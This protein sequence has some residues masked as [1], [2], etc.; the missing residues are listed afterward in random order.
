MEG[1]LSASLAVVS[2]GTLPFLVGG[3]ALGVLLGA[4]PGVTGAMGI[5]LLLPLTFYMTVNNA[6]TLMVSMYVGAIAGGLV[7]AIL[8]RIPGEPSSIVTTFD[9]NPMARKGQPGKA[10]G[11]AVGAS[12][13]GGLVSWAALVALTYPLSEIAVRLRPF[14]LL[15]LVMMALVLIAALGQGSI[16]KGLISGLLGILV[17]MPG[18]DPSAGN[19]RLTFGIH[20]LDAGFSTLAVLIGAYAV[21]QVMS[22]LIEVERKVETVE[23]TMGSMWISMREWKAQW[24]NLIRSSVI[25]T[26]VGIMPGIGA[27]VGSLV[28]YTVAKTSSKT[29]EKFGTG[30]PDGIVAS[31]CGNNA[32][33]GGALVPLIAMGIPGS[34]TDVFLLAALVIHGLQPGP[35][36]FN[37]HPEIVYV[38]FAACLISHFVLFVIMTAG[39]RYLIKLMTV[40][41]WYLFPIILL[42]CLIG[43]FADN[44]RVFDVLI[45][46]CF[47]VVGFCMEKTG[48]SLGAFVI[49]FVLGPITEKSLRAGLTLSDGS[50]LDIFMHPI[51]GTCMVLSAA[52]FVWSLR[53]QHRINKLAAQ[54]GE[55]AA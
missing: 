19:L 4:I 46:L 35:L 17:S 32:T 5:A 22:D 18:T 24:W 25:G 40:P 13:F 23:T 15:A 37:Q 20:D 7:T 41:V 34:V 45:M 52:M 6:L 53:S 1:F 36:L 44:N 29:P 26:W 49:G 38:I 27:T 47:A 33:V 54:G 31:E 21:A 12:L 14:D 39:I 55:A 11:Y 28:S 10:L 30:H 9:G 16:I 3:T 48:F 43:A 50:Y 42:F 8:L 2:P 51:S